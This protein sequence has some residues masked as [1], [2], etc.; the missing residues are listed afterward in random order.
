[1]VIM[2]IEFK[3]DERKSKDRREMVIK[4]VDKEM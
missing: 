3:L 1:M 4:G 2:I